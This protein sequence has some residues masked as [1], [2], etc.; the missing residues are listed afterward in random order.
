MG[1]ELVNY[2]PC[3]SLTSNLYY[4]FEKN[5]ALMKNYPNASGATKLQD[6]KKGAYG[7]GYI[8]WQEGTAPNLNKFYK[9]YEFAL[10]SEE[11]LH[12]CLRK[13]WAVWRTM[14]RGSKP[15]EAGATDWE[16]CG[17]TNLAEVEVKGKIDEEF[18]ENFNGVRHN[19]L[20]L[21]GEQ[22]RGRFVD[23]KMNLAEELKRFKDTA[24][25]FM[26][27]A[28][29]KKI[30]ADSQ[31]KVTLTEFE[32]INTTG[33]N[34]LGILDKALEGYQVL[35]FQIRETKALMNLFFD[36]WDFRVERGEPDD[37]DLWTVIWDN[38]ANT[39]DI[40]VKREA[41]NGLPVYHTFETAGRLSSGANVEEPYWMIK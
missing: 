21:Q 13:C 5:G 28:K 4:F 35:D 34:I 17:C 16:A 24:D 25:L 7:T 2:H 23:H 8:N 37:F 11:T 26:A 3:R 15:L 38:Q 32:G 18:I 19:M 39:W 6:I 40:R 27:Y 36:S 14:V 29:E 22:A 12:Y 41:V 1:A 30:D 33:K 9:P 10:Q 31:I 20:I